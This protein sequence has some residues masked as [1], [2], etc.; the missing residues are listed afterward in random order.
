VQHPWNVIGNIQEGL[1]NIIG[2]NDHAQFALRRLLQNLQRW[3]CL[4]LKI[5]KGGLDTGQHRHRVE[6]AGDD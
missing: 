4:W 1:L 2:K 3:E 5:L 6:I